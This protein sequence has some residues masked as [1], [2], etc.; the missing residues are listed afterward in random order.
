MTQ[1]EGD[2]SYM[3]DETTPAKACDDLL[4]NA[5][6]S[7]TSH[8]QFNATSKCLLFLSLR[9]VVSGNMSKELEESSRSYL[10]V[11]RRRMLQFDSQSM[12]PL[13]CCHETSSAFLRSDVSLKKPNSLDVCLFYLI[14]ASPFPSLLELHDNFR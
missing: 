12:D 4:F 13:L 11:K 14:N 1:D 3:F 5:G 9:N 2:I 6:G 7:G 10:R 8:W